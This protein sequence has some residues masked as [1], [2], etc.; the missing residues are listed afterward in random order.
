M[1]VFLLF[2]YFAKANSMIVPNWILIMTW[3]IAVAGWY[4]KLLAA[5]SKIKSKE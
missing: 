4:T 3:V 2:L 1:T 5:M